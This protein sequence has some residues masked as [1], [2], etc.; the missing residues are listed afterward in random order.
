M[1]SKRCLQTPASVLPYGVDWS[2]WLPAG[3]TI[4]DSQWTI[5][6]QVEG[7]PSLSLDGHDGTTTWVT[8]TGAVVGTTHALTNTV[9]LSQGSVDPRTI[10]IKGVAQKT[11]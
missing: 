8:V 10:Y 6:G 5:D 9:T 2:A 7:V 3:A 4:T 1:P 11:T